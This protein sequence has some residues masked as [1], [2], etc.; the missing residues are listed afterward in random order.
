M[1]CPDKHLEKLDAMLDSAFKSS[2]KDE[3]EEPKDDKKDNEDRDE[4][5]TG[6]LSKKNPS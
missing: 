6:A 5:R 2:K 3:L 4:L 1:P